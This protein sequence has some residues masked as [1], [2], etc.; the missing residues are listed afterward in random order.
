MKQVEFVDLDT[1]YD[2][3]NVGS[4][5]SFY[6]F[7]WSCI[8]NVKGYNFAVSPEDFRYDLRVLRNYKKLIKKNGTVIIVIC[9]LSFAENRYLLKDYYSYRYIGILPKS[10]VII[11][12]YKYKI[13][14]N[15]IGR[16]LVN[17]YYR[18]CAVPQLIY[19]V[20][21]RRNKACQSSEERLVR[22][23]LRDNPD[24]RNLKDL[25]KRDMTQV[26]EKKKKELNEIVEECINANLRPVLLIP[27]ISRKLRSY[28]SSEFLDAFVYNNIKEISDAVILLDFLSDD[29]YSDDL[30]YSNGIFLKHEIAPEFTREVISRLGTI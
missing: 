12:S 10:E 16:F 9:P 3:V 29:K 20:L 21:G 17:N 5:P 28:F 7:D 19:S 8:L 27:P 24:L 4:G 30:F 1:L 11:S 23:W 13:Y 2:I 25:P 18:M 26:F 22:G 14:K 15:K 6:D